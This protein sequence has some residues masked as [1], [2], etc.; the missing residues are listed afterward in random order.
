MVPEKPNRFWLIGGLLLA[1]I[2][3][4]AFRTGELVELESYLDH[5]TESDIVRTTQTVQFVIPREAQG[6]VLSAARLES[7]NYAVELEIQG[8]PS[9]GRG[10]GQRAWVIYRKDTSG[11]ELD[12]APELARWAHITRDTPAISR[13]VNPMNESVALSLE[14]SGP[15]VAVEAPFATSND[16]A[17]VER[18]ASEARWVKSMPVNSIKGRG[19]ANE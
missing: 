19:L 11:L 15:P 9:E 16:K 14:A 1:I 5:Q 17:E 4:M 6:K 7:G 18:E 13:L 10:A 2:F 8:T 12:A 3:T